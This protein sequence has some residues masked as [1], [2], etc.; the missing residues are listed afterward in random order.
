MKTAKRCKPYQPL[1]S[2]ITPSINSIFN[3]ILSHPLDN[4]PD[5]EYFT[6]LMFAGEGE[7]VTEPMKFGPKQKKGLCHPSSPEGRK[8]CN[9]EPMFGKEWAPSTYY[10]Y[11]ATVSFFCSWEQTSTKTF[12]V[13]VISKVYD[14]NVSLNKRGNGWYIN[15]KLF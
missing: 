1:F 4:Q 13:H 10:P 12:Y 7:G 2:H 15:N 6:L 5:E 11:Y 9:G 3:V 14:D 8:L